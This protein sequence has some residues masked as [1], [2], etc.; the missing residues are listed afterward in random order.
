MFAG[1]VVVN[2]VVVLGVPSGPTQTKGCPAWEFPH[3]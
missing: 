2:L 1:V 3:T